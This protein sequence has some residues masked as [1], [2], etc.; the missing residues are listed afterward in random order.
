MKFS[1]QKSGGKRLEI[2]EE[3]EQLKSMV[4]FVSKFVQQQNPMQKNS[5][6]SVSTRRASSKSLFLALC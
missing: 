1:K 6:N 2:G 5:I 4:H 3:Q